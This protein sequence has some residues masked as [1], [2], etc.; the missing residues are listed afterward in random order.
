MKLSLSAR[1]NFFDFLNFEIIS[2]LMWVGL[3]CFW[4]HFNAKII[5]SKLT[6]KCLKNLI[7]HQ[8]KFKT[9]SLQ[10]HSSV[11]LSLKN[12]PLYNDYHGLF[13]NTN[14]LIIRWASIICGNDS[15]IAH[16]Q[17]W[18]RIQCEKLLIQWLKGV[19]NGRF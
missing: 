6:K 18:K 16:K 10:L 14:I 11:E 1:K 9:I 19:A 4:I 3:H 13:L 5:I 7:F 15:K 12:N 2:L 8:T 17:I